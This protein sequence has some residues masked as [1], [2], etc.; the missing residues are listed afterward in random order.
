MDIAYLI[1]HPENLDRDTLYDLRSLLALYP[2][3]QSA[4]LLLLQCLFLLH[5]P[6]FDE[7]LRRAALYITDR[8]VLFNLVE[9]MHYQL[10]RQPSEEKAE[11]KGGKTVKPSADRTIS[12]IDN[13]LEQIPEDKKEEETK[14]PKRKPTPADAAGAYQPHACR[15]GCRLCVLFAVDRRV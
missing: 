5:D 8:K 9:A 1:K 3:Y 14:K 7:E 10:R 6:S 2:Y 13:F 12:L 15:C 4:R 11:Q